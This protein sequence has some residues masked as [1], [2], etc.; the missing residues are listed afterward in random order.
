M[1]FEHLGDVGGNDRNRVA[2][3]DA[4]G[5][6]GAGKAAATVRPLMARGPA[7]NTSTAV[8]GKASRATL[9][10]ICEIP[11]AAISALKSA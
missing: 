10:P 11:R 3:G 9:A 4:A 8:S 1:G 6:Q 5:R 2:P 7:P